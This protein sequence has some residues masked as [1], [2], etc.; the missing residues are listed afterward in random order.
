MTDNDL[1][2]RFYEDWHICSGDERSE[3]QVLVDRDVMA[4]DYISSC[5]KVLEIGCGTGT[6]LSHISASK[7][8]GVDISETAVSYAKKKGLEAYK[9]DIDRQNLDFADKE[10][11]GI[12]C[13]EV[14]EHLFDPVHALAEAN[15]V[16]VQGGKMAI[17]VPNIG[18]WHYRLLHLFGTFTDL[19]GN[20]LIVDEHIRF[21]TKRSM[22]QIIELCGF[23]IERALGAAKQPVPVVGK[24]SEKAQNSDRSRLSWAT[25][26]RRVL[27][28]DSL[29][30]LLIRCVKGLFDYLHLWRLYPSLFAT[31]LVFECIKI[32]DPLYK[33]NTAVSHTKRTAEEQHLNVNIP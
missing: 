4:I 16:L 27:R 29:A 30:M 32:D 7:R 28:R 18:C 25:K 33:Y 17:T 20:G 10:F 13:I 11:D 24:V 12:L 8:C 26:V 31:G 23:A 3:S 19:H 1:I 21:Y 15:R 9:V 5:D 22:T 2:Q 6:V 14:L